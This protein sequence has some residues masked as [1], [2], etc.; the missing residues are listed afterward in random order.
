MLAQN[1]KRHPS[2]HDGRRLTRDNQ[3]SPTYARGGSRR[4]TRRTRGQSCMRRRRHLRRWKLCCRRSP[5]ASVR[6]RLWHW[7]TCEE[8]IFYAPA[9]RRVFVELPPEDYQPADERM[10]GLL[11]YSLYGTCDA[12]QNWEEELAS[13]LTGLGLTRGSVVPVRVARTHQG[14]ARRCNRAWR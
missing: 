11:R 2:R 13:T 14:E 5:R 12:V 6:E 3:E 1:K 4:S 10:C 9:R 7:S 8:R